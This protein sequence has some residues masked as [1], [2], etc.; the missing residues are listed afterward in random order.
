MKF[1]GLKKKFEIYFSGTKTKLFA[2][3][4]LTCCRSCIKAALFP[5]KVTAGPFKCL[6]AVTRSSFKDERHLAN[7]ASP[8]ITLS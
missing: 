3:K 6:E 7:T 8:G 4:K 2:L 5:L 1:D